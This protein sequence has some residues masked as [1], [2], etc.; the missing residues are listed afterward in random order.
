MHGDIDSWGKELCSGER[1]SDIEWGVGFIHAVWGKG[2]GNHNDFLWRVS[3]VRESCRACAVRCMVS[4][5]WVMRKCWCSDCRTIWQR[6]VRSS[7]VR[8]LLSL[9][10]SSEFCRVA[11]CTGDFRRMWSMTGE[12]TLMVSDRGL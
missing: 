12:R 2:S 1:E 11:S 6:R 3:R 7:S 9:L 8:S 4:V 5:P 10:K